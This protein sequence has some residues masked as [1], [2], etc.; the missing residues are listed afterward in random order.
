MTQMETVGRTGIDG[1]SPEDG[2]PIIDIALP[3]GEL[4]VGSVDSTNDRRGL[5]NDYELY[6][7]GRLP[8]FI[9]TFHMA[10][11]PHAQKH[12]EFLQDFDLVI[13]LPLSD[14]ENTMANERVRVSRVASKNRLI[15]LLKKECLDSEGNVST[16]VYEAVPQ[17]TSDYDGEK[18]S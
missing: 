8:Y 16:I 2:T 5:R 11:E 18:F 4:A 6:M 9:A 7:D 13:E 10:L 15:N 1:L 17:G 14:A 12:A 3:A